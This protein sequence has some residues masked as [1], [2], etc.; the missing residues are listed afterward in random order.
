[1][2]PSAA[3]SFMVEVYKVGGVVLVLLLL[4]A[5]ACVYF[6]KFLVGQVNALS[7][8]VSQVETEKTQIL[9]THLK[10]NTSGLHEI[11]NQTKRQTDKLEEVVQAL[12]SRPCM[13]E[14]GTYVKPTL[15]Q[16]HLPQRGL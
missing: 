12:R 1:M 4:L 2:E 5:A 3:A 15:P 16:V 14:T 10:D 13:V 7:A 6:G 11:A 8:R 9:V